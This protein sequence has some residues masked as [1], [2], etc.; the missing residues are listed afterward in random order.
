MHGTRIFLVRS[1]PHPSFVDQSAEDASANVLT[2][3]LAGTLT[4]EIIRIISNIR[5]ERA[6]DAVQLNGC[7]R[8]VL[9]DDLSDV[10]NITHI[11]LSGINSLEGEYT[12]VV[13]TFLHPSF[14]NPIAGVAFT[15]VLQVILH[16]WRN[17][18]RWW[19]LMPVTQKFWV[20]RFHAVFFADQSANDAFANIPQVTL[21]F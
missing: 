17:A 3:F 13:R 21:L 10:A 12:T 15:N 1:F 8:F 9:A 4:G 19:S 11:D 16:F 2:A 7:G 5:R 18:D 6:K 14:A 20:R